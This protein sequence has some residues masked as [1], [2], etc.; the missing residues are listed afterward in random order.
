MLAGLAVTAAWPGG[1]WA[2]PAIGLTIAAAT[3]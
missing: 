3:A 2:D 1:W